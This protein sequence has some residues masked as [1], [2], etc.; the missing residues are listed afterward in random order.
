MDESQSVIRA[1]MQIADAIAR[2][3]TDAIV[4]L[5]A[6][7][8]LH[9]TPGRETRDADAFVSGIREIPGEIIFVRVGSLEV[10]L[11]N[12]GAL[13]TG[14]QHAQVR[15]DGKDIDDRRAFVDWFVKHGGEWRIRVA[16]D[17]PAAQG[18]SAVSEG[19]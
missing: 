18:V 17:L 19:G 11:S 8:F 3:D 12:A 10:D 4:A 13:V 1:A 16:V 15:I 9:R 6:P 2:R 5:L 7:G 14:I